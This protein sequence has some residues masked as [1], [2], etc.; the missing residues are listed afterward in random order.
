MPTRPEIERIAAMMNALRPDWRPSS[1]VTFLET[2][3]AH[4]PYRDLAIAAAVVATDARTQT[5]QLLN[6]HGPWWVAAQ[7]ATGTT[8]TGVVAATDP[9]CDVPG[10]EYEAARNCRA[11]RSEAIAAD[12]TDDPP[13]LGITPEQ[14]ERNARWA[15]QAKAALTADPTPRT[16]DV[17]ELAAHNR[18]ED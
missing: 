5:P 3:Q 13:V 16:P 7:A 6:E 14:A 1:L 8:S 9:R 12:P 17:R 10:H 2:H 15:A 18:L 11:C 4:R